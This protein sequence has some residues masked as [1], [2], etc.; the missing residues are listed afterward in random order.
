MLKN[1][2]LKLSV[3]DYWKKFS[4][5]VIR[6]SLDGSGKRAQYIRKGTDWKIIENNF[7]FVKNKLH[8]INL[9]IS[10]V[11]QLTNALH[12]PDFYQDWIDK[13][14]L[15]E[16]GLHNTFLISLTG[17]EQLSAHILPKEVKVLVRE[18]WN[19]FIDENLKEK[20][21]NFKRYINDCLD[22]MD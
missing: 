14:L 6:V 3:V 5:V 4:N 8:N 17:P 19:R 9:G 1:P 18:K 10:S 21:F 12:I 15:D 2:K 22:Y 11:F 16:E 20:H 7:R 13:G